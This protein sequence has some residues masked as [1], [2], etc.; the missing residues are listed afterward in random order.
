MQSIKSEYGDAI[1]IP[2]LQPADRHLKNKSRF[3]DSEYRSLF[4]S[5]PRGLSQYKDI[6]LPV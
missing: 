6:V 4:S 1:N 2:I 5:K 3:Y